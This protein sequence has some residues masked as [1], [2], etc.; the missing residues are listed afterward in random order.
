[1]RNQT[2]LC[3]GEPVPSN[4][5]CEHARPRETRGSFVCNEDA[6]NEAPA[7]GTIK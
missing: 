6:S 7:K 3:Q 4:S 2:C 1:M 5:V